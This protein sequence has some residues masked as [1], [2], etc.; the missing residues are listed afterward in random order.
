MSA[1]RRR[2][3][4]RPEPAPE[5]D[6]APSE[7]AGEETATASPAPSGQTPLLDVLMAPEEAPP[8]T[9]GGEQA[10]RGAGGFA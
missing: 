10:G 8:S 4:S 7:A 2:H 3:A 5:L 6:V 9:E 1:L